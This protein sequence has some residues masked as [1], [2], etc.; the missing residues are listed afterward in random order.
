MVTSDAFQNYSSCTAEVRKKQTRPL[1]A[2]IQA[3]TLALLTVVRMGKV[4]RVQLHVIY[5]VYQAD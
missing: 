5:N 1:P 4:K 3:M 2:M